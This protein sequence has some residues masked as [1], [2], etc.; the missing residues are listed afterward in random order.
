[1]IHAC[2]ILD[3]VVLSRAVIYQPDG[4]EE[5]IKNFVPA[6]GSILLGEIVAI[7]PVTELLMVHQREI[8]IF[9]DSQ[10]AV[11]IISMNRVP[12]HHLQS[13]KMIENMSSLESKG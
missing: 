8:R 3:H 9:S 1:M 4:Q 6:F 13:S 11:E 12:D 2:Q 5:C 7:L 10:K